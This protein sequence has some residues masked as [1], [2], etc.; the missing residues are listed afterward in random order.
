MVSSDAQDNPYRR[1]K[2]R[3]T[4]RQLWAR[5]QSG[6]PEVR[7][8]DP[9][10]PPPSDEAAEA[11]LPIELV[12]QDELEEAVFAEAEG[13]PAAEAEAHA[14]HGGELGIEVPSSAQETQ[15]QAEGEAMM[16]LEEPGGEPAAEDEPT[17]ETATADENEEGPR[18]VDLAMQPGSMQYPFATHGPAP[19]SGED[20]PASAEL[21]RRVS[22]GFV[23]G[24]LIIV[25]SLVAGIALVRV[26]R[27]VSQLE[28]SIVELKELLPSSAA[29][30]E[31]KPG[32]SAADGTH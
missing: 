9:A 28:S 11:G 10:V 17:G 30:D 27:R 2:K 22:T 32:L 25:A 15:E 29:P 21:E 14:E 13:E 23:L 19:Q 12:V 18:M 24:A 3:V 31:R 7:E 5:G 16:D 20:E 8:E 26:S 6:P 4:P 1:R